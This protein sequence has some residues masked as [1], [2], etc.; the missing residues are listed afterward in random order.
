[1]SISCLPPKPP[2]TRLVNTRTSSR[3]S[4]KTWHSSSRTRNGTCE[5]VRITKRPSS[6]RQPVQPWVSR[7]ACWTRAVLHRPPHHRVPRLAAAARRR[8]RR[9]RRATRRR[10]CATGP[11]SGHRA[12]LSPCTRGAPGARAASGSNTAG[13]SSY[14]TVIARQ[15]FSAIARLS[16]TTAATRCPTKRTVSS[17][18]WVS[19][20][21]S[22][23]SSWRAV[24]NGTGGLS[25]WVST[26]R[27]PGDGLGGGG[28][29][30]TRSARAAAGCP[31]RPGA[32]GPAARSPW[33]TA[34]SRSPPGRRRVR[35]VSGPRRPPLDFSVLTVPRQRVGDRAIPGAAAEVS[36]QLL[37]QVGQLRRRSASTRW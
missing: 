17:S 23:R 8:R 29:D 2:P 24:E 25:R 9:P 30:R 4:P 27:T 10:R 28:V 36:L 3:S 13:S 12:P 34:R 35:R 37:G 22:S 1:M 15:A 19:S 14:S 11:R 7:C 32:A 33:C 18:T 20:G 31:A 5:L 21:S 26:S 16:A 6:S